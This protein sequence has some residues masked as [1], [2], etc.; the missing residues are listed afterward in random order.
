MKIKNILSMWRF[1]YMFKSGVSTAK[2]AICGLISGIVIGVALSCMMKKQ[3][4]VKRKAGKA[5]QAVGELMEQIPT[6]FKA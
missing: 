5:L 6:A 1:L 3:K 2:S 4:K